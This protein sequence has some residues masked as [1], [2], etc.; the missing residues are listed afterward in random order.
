MIFDVSFTS[1]TGSPLQ[2]CDL[3]RESEKLG[4][5]SVWIAHD[6]LSDNA[7]VACGAIARST[8]KIMVGP[9]IV[10]PYS[11]SLPE[12]AMAAATLDNLSG[13]RALLGI[14]P[15][16]K[17]MLEAAGIEQTRVISRLGEAI[18][19]LGKALKPRSGILNLKLGKSIPIFLGGQSPRLLEHAGMWGVGALPLLTP[20]SYAE[21]A[22]RAIVRGAKRAG[23]EV[24]RSELVAS[25]LVSLAK[26]REEALKSFA[27][28]ITSI[29]KY[30]SPYQLEP[31]GIHATEVED[32][33]GTY[34]EK[35]W[36]ALPEKVYGLGVT[37]V[38][39]LIRTLE[40]ISRAG[41][42]RVKCGSPQGPDKREALR[43]LA[44]SVVPRFK[45]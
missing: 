2:L 6:L 9:G 3:A 7:W 40:Q 35:G 41:F 17:L 32:L 13:G 22:M 12:I 44:K 37:D 26:E 15:G 25:I 18:S 34:S 27:K 45:S 39:S 16:A 33:L 43:I 4:F 24:K 19:Y 29:L 14:G 8:S 28:F 36:Q 23:I 11:T 1:A 42:R 38:E 30:L 5:H 31:A 10:N 20:P 21:T